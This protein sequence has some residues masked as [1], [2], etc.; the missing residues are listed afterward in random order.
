MSGTFL[1]N[2]R[3]NEFL[4]AREY[5]IEIAGPFEDERTGRAVETAL[6]STLNP[7]FNVDP[8]PSRWRFRPL[9]VP[10]EFADR[11]V[12]PELMLGDFLSAQGQAPA[13][14]LFVIVT[15]VDFADERVGYN[16]ANPPTDA[17]IRPRVD[18]WWQLQRFLP[19]W[20]ANPE[21]SPGLL[22]GVFGSPGRQTVIA[23][24]RIDRSRWEDAE[25]FG[26]GKISV[27]LVEPTA[28]DAFSL[29]GRRIGRGA[30]LMFGGIPAQFFIFLG[31]DGLAVGGHHLRGEKAV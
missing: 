14:V 20:S 29:R 25:L 23:S 17:Q 5:R 30:G 28:L 2:D 12:E 31:A 13:P 15:S 3:L 10:L 18:R 8:G 1:P 27:P 4:D 7:E 22:I 26:G 24:A 16:P 9:G 11:Q 6:I 21:S 19:A